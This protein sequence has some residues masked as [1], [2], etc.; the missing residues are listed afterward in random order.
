MKIKTLAVTMLLATANLFAND[1]DSLST[2]DTI[3]QEQAQLLISNY[4]DS[5]T[6]SFNYQTGEVLINTDL[7]TI[8]VPA[9]FKYLNGED[10]ETVLTTLWGN[11]PSEGADK[12]LGMIVPDNF[13]PYSDSTFSINITYSE[14]GYVED[15]DAAD[16]DYDELLEEL[17]ASA[18]EANKERVKLGY[19]TVEIVGWAAAPYYDHENKKL[20]WA[21]EIKFDGAEEN[22]LNYNIRILGRKGYLQLNAI[23]GMSVLNRVND[24]INPI[25]S[26]VDFNPGNQYADFDSSIDEVAAYGIGGLIAGKALLKAGL[27]AKLGILLAKF[28]KFILLGVVGIGAAVKKLFFKGSEE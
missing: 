24:N 7:A 15:D 8:N 22:T 19:G 6:N 4:V 14:E 12:S 18:R 3:T 27:L 2:N 26:S 23:G 5:I 25:L 10:S 16:I 21:K 9:G 1:A 13:D 11:P 17:Q 28:W 20:H